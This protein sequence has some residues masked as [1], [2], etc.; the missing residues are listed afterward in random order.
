MTGSTPE[1]ALAGGPGATIGVT[2]TG[3]AVAV[4]AYCGTDLGAG[5]SDRRYCDSRCRAKAHKRRRRER[6]DLHLVE[7]AP[8]YGSGSAGPVDEELEDDDDEELQ[9]A[10]VVSIVKAARAGD[11]RASAWLLARRWPQRY[12]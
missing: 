10:L 2:V 1:V 7:P 9:A 8:S 4:C 5:R 11:W 6:P 12:A 3:M